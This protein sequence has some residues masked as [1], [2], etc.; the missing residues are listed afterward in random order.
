[1]EEMR[2]SKIN[3]SRQLSDKKRAIEGDVILSNPDR[4]P[5]ERNR[6]APLVM[7]PARACHP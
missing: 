7:P 6:L 5:S 2:K 3:S 1:M 4:I